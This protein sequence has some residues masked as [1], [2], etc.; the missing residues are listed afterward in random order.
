MTVV[1]V[2]A[3]QARGTF[4]YYHTQTWGGEESLDPASRQGWE[5][6]IEIVYDRLIRLDRGGRPRPVLAES[7]EVNPF[8]TIWEFSIRNGVTF[9]DGRPLTA[10]DVVLTIQHYLDPDVASPLASQLN[11]FEP[12]RLDLF[13]EFTFRVNL[14][15]PR[16]DLPLSLSNFAFRIIPEGGLGDIQAIAGIGTGPFMPEQLDVDGVSSLVSRDDYWWGLPGVEGVTLLPIP[17]P[18][19]RVA[20]L[21][22]GR[23]DM[24]TGLSPNQVEQFDGNPNFVVQENPTGRV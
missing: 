17:E 11:L 4:N 19:T 13:D 23:I 12:L 9:S 1:A 15:E 16:A 20:A 8:A 14:A 2:P 22:T 10:K 24:I 18:A 6:V 7:W 21:L 3:V 5:P